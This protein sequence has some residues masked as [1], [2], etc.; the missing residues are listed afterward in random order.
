M[1]TAFI[2]GTVVI[3]SVVVVYSALA[4]SSTEE[5]AY[6]KFDNPFKKNRHQ[7]FTNPTKNFSFEISEELDIKEP[8]E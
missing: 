1:I 5:K 2:V 7:P 3:L 6:Q 4:I 8:N